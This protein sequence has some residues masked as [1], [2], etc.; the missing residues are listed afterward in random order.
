MNFQFTNVVNMFDHNVYIFS[1]SPWP[2]V[3]RVC[4]VINFL[5]LTVTKFI[6]H[7]SSQMWDLIMCS[8]VQWISR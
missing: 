8:L 6:D 1:A 3:N 2:V 4:T 7:I 5:N